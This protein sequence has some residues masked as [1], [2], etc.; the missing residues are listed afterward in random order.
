MFGQ[1]LLVRCAGLIALALIVTACQKADTPTAT[2]ELAATPKRRAEIPEVASRPSE[3]SRSVSSPIGLRYEILGEPRVAEP[4]QIR[5][6]SQSQVVVRE[7]V[8]Q[9]RGDEG[10]SVSPS[11]ANFRLAQVAV[12]EPIT[13]TVTVTPLAEGSHRL[14]VSAQGEIN[15]LLQANNVTIRIQVGGAEKLPEQAGTLKTDAEGETIISLPLQE[16]PKQRP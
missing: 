5:I 9:V 2:N 13:R 4:L 6:T 8:L 10:L 15:G 12:G 16:S 1:P 14:S 7:M 3:R 11:T